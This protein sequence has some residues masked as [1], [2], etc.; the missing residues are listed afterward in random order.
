MPTTPRLFLPGYGAPASLY[1]RPLRGWTVAR[2]PSFVESSGSLDVYQCWALHEL[3]RVGR[4][5]VLGGHSFGGALSILA[6]AERP[7]LVSRLVLVGPA[8]LPLDKPIPL[9]V[10]AFARQLVRGMYPLAEAAAALGPAVRA[11]R[12][13]LRLA[14][15]IRALDLQEECARVRRAGIPVRVIGCASDTLV[16]TS[17][18]R[19]LASLLGARY[20]ELELAG[21]HMWMLREGTRFADELARA[22]A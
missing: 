11:P 9:S 6:A 7:E 1:A 20:R 3:E 4:P 10:A 19:R 16:T 5:A 15:S 2:P 13:A 18:T 21:G 22:L 12:A 8:G 17:R 14:R